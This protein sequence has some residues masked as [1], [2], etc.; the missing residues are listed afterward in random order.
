MRVSRE[1]LL[2]TI[3]REASCP[4]IGECAESGAAAFLILGATC[5]RGCRYCAVTQGRPEIPLPDEHLRLACAV[6]AL[7]LRYVVITS[8]T[9][10]DLA[11]CGAGAFAR[12]VSEIRRASPNCKVETLVPDFAS[13]QQAAVATI[14]ASQ[15]HVFAHNIEA[16]KSVY[17]AVRPLGDYQGSLELLASAASAGCVVKAGFMTGF[18]ETFD[19]AAA[20]VRDLYRAGA[21]LLSVGQYYP[22]FAGAYP[23]RRL[24]TDGEFAALRELALSLG[25]KAAACGAAV[26]SSYH[27]DELYAA[28]MSCL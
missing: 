6:S 23:L 10:D 13:N 24:W 14:A 19:D 21:R 12:A 9:R 4:N 16:A 11:D 15:P 28:Y 5:S 8:V 20:T 26:R 18:G 22:S 2:R 27:A 25:F 3:C 1:N 7:N 17:K